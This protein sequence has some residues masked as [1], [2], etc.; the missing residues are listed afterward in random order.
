M[1]SIAAVIPARYASTRLPGKPLVDLAGKTMI[2]RV[3]EQV[4]KSAVDKIIVATDHQLIE[5]EVDS[6]GGTC[7]V[8]GDFPSGTDRVAAVAKDLTHDAI[9][10]V[11]G[12][13]PLIDPAHID[14]LASKLRRGASLVSMMAQINSARQLLDFNTVK[15][16]CSSRGQALYFSRQAIP[17][18]RDLPYK[19]WL[20]QSIP[21]F[22][23]LGIYG[24]Q[25]SVLQEIVALPTST[26]E[27]TEQLEQLRW[28]EAGYQIEMIEVHH[29]EKGV[30][31]KEDLERVR[32]ILVP[33]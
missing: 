3:Y 23:H 25:S 27:Q 11:Q 13:E 31:T 1:K 20:S 33:Q 9:I 24:Y 21:Y 19:D 16:V 2:R 7:I 10:N 6:W 29:S 14:A 17:A 5:D 22:Q 4:A 12:D 8:T 18:H 26:L 28:L 30:D 32:A 15:V